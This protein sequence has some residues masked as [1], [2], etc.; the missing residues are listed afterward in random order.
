MARASRFD[1]VQRE[2]HRDAHE[3][4]LRQ[5]EAAA[6][7]RTGRPGSSG[8][9]ASA[10]R[11]SRTAGRAA[12]SSAAP[13]VFRSYCEQRLVE[14][15]DLDAVLDEAREVLGVLRAPSRLAWL[16]RPSPRSAGASSSRRAVTYEYAG[17]FS[18][19][20]RAESTTPLRTSSIG[21]P[22]YR[23]FSVALRMR[24]GSTSARPAHDVLTSVGEALDVERLA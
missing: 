17:S 13:S 8:R 23:S 5:L 7:A 9:T 22:S 6:A 14:Q 24:S 3:E 20:V 16:P 19:S 1:L 4:A 10:G 21:T 12:A 15:A 18:I 11:G 2:A